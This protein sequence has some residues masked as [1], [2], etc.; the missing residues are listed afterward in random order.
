MCW[1]GPE[2]LSSDQSSALTTRLNSSI[3]LLKKARRDLCPGRRDE[4]NAPGSGGK[5]REESGAQVRP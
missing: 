5:G 4:R 2:Q 3:G 1:N